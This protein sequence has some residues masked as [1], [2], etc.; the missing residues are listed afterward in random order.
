VTLPWILAIALPIAAVFAASRHL[1]DGRGVAWR[2]ALALGLGPGLAAVVAWSLLVAG[3]ASRELFLTIDSSLWIAVLVTA[4]AAPPSHPPTAAVAPA[5]TGAERGTALAWLVLVVASGVAAA[6]F[7]VQSKLLPHG[8]WDAWAIW[9]LKA[10]FFARGLDAQAWRDAF[11]SAL[12][13]SH[14]DYPLL[15]PLAVARAWICAGSENVLVPAGVALAFALG[16]VVV[17]GAS[18]ARARGVRAGVVAASF[19]AAAPA[20]VRYA[21]SQCAD[22]PLAYFI[23]VTLALVAEAERHGG[24]RRRWA[25]AG[26]AGALAAWSKNEG[27]LFFALMAAAV[28]GHLLLD[29]RRS[30]AV[31]AFFAGSAPVLLALGAFKLLLSPGNDLLGAQNLADGKR[32]AAVG[33]AMGRELW[34]G[35]ADWLGVLPILVVFVLLHGI[36]RRSGCAVAYGVVVLPAMLLIYGVVYVITPYDLQWHLSTSLAR[37]VLHLV[38]AAV[39]LAAM[40]VSRQ[41]PT[42]T[43]P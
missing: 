3:V 23:V 28:L 13:G 5:V 21:P 27:I 36:R 18:V 42:V 20:F 39:W 37:L 15:L 4:L 12:A 30:R 9:N 10:R 26:V 1:G 29:R 40:A 24:D 19:V 11:S 32:I 41:G 2:L 34:F 25:A 43:P 22:V 33:A 14:P 38:P 7:V 31:V 16:L 6:A 8:T 35:G 17:V